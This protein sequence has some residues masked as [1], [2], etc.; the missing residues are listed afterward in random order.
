M[1][2]LFKNVDFTHYSVKNFFIDSSL[3]AFKDVNDFNCVILLG[4]LIYT[5]IYFRKGSFSY[6]FLNEVLINLLFTIFN[7]WFEA[8]CCKIIWKRILVWSV[9]LNLLIWIE[10][11]NVAFSTFLIWY[12]W[13]WWRN[14]DASSLFLKTN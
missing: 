10:F 11:Q 5:A 13:F 8:S 6:L 4:L 9:L 7:W 2:E 3:N 12:F 1:I 14:R